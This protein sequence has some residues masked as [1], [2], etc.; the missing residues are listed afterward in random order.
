MTET[1]TFHERM[2][3]AR[4]RWALWCA[5]HGIDPRTATVRQVQDAVL[6]HRL[7]GL[8]VDDA[9]DLLDAAAVASGTWRDTRILEMRRSL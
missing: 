9:V 2:S 7:A 5:K 3:T 4:D 8:D 1:T 6:D